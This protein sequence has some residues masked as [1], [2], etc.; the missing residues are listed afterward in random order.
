MTYWVRAVLSGR[1]GAGRW[2]ESH[3]VCSNSIQK[4]EL[5]TTVCCIE[6]KSF[7]AQLSFFLSVC[8][9]CLQKKWIH[10]DKM[11]FYLILFEWIKLVWFEHLM[12]L[13]ILSDHII[14]DSL[15]QS[16]NFVSLSKSNHRTKTH[17]VCFSGCHDTSLRPSSLPARLRD[18]SP[19]PDPHLHPEGGRWAP[20]HPSL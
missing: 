5:N 3:R 6:E 1:L 13:W 18:V 4:T 17:L 16:L 15:F 7:E 10:L 14:V 12:I 9:Q 8:A 11:H 2:R 20:Q 19:R